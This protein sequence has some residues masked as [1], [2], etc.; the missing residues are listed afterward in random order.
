MMIIIPLIILLVL[1]FIV[2]IAVFQRIMKQNVVLATKHLDQMNQDYSRKEQE[3]D[4][5]LE[6]TR[7]KCHSMLSKAQEEAQ[8]LKE[9]IINEAGIE[10]DRTIEQARKHSEEIIKQA[11]SSRKMLLSEI[12]D[13]ISKEAADK[14][15]ELLQNTLP[16]QIK[17]DVHLHW[18][19]ELIASDYSHLERLRIPKDAQEIKIVSAFELTDAQRRSL[20]KRLKDAIGKDMDTKEEVD[21]KIV[22]GVIIYIGSLVLDGS[23]KN[24]LLEQSKTFQTTES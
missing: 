3:I 5:Q 13:R 1:V 9:K 6:E 19:E 15:C 17:R 22:S 24:K 21:P 8:S 16:E 12:N 10:R 7:Q 14:A 11:D 4:Q 20:Y 23:L 2:M 18:L